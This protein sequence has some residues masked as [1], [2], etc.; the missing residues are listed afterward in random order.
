VTCGGALDAYLEELY[1]VPQRRGWTLRYPS[2][3]RGFID[4]YRPAASRVTPP[5]YA[6]ER[7]SF[8]ASEMIKHTVQRPRHPA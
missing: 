1:V 6:G 2:W 4:A 7:S 5:A 8:H 3:R